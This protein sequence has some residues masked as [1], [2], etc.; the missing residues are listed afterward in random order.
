MYRR[1]GLNVELMVVPD[2]AHEMEKVNSPVEAY[3]L[4]QLEQWHFFFGTRIICLGSS[5][6]F[7]AVS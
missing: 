7:L 3:M 2:V 5:A 1:G 6:S 4:K